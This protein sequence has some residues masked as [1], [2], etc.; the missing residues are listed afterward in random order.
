MRALKEICLGDLFYVACNLRAEEWDNVN[1]MLGN[2]TID[3]Y[4]LRCANAPGPKWVYADDR[5]W[6]AGG[7][8]PQRPGVYQSWFLACLD[9]WSIIPLEVTQVAIERI[10]FMLDNG[11]HRVETLCPAS[12]KLA[13]RWYKTIGLKQEATLEAYCADGT[14]AVIYARTR[15]L[16]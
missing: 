7:F 11:A 15:G 10:A 2:Q 1:A 8:V 13:Q 3:S 14:S 5:P 16:H 12:N 6:I 4:I 9:A